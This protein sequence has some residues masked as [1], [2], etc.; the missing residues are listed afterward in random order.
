MG[1]VSNVTARV[2]FGYFYIMSTNLRKYVQEN[3]LCLTVFIYFF[4]CCIVLGDNL[5][6]RQQNCCLHQWFVA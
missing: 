4:L 1:L 2:V 5:G 3:N 6:L